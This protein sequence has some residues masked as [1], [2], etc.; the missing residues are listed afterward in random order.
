[1]VDRRHREVAALVLDLVAAVA[2]LLDAAGVPGAGHGVDGVVAGVLLGLEAHVVEDVELGLGREE[3]GVADAGGGQEVLRLAG[4]VARVAAVGLLGQR[5]VHEEVQA[6]GLGD[7]EG[8]QVGR[9][10]VGQQGHVRLVDLLEAA[11]RRAVEGQAVLEHLGPE[12]AG[13]NGEVLH[14]AGQVAEPDVDDLDALVLD[15]GQHLV[16]VVEHVSSGEGRSS[17]RI[18]RAQYA[19]S[20]A[21]VPRNGERPPPDPKV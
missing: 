8:V 16:G 17:V 7:P 13:R 4:D 15:V 3:R 20:G 19:G 21:P 18:I 11:D 5:V 6:E 2:A 14:G 1:M 9:R 12:R 10:R